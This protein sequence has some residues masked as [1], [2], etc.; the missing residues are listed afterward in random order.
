MYLPFE[1]T[2]P[3]LDISQSILGKRHAKIYLLWPYLLSQHFESNWNAHTWEITWVKSGK[4]VE[5]QGES[6]LT[7]IK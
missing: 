7:N 3:L 4:K 6:Q 5:K 1:S 2:I